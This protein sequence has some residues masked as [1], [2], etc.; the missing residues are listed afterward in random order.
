[1]MSFHLRLER[2]KHLLA[3]LVRATEY[4]VDLPTKAYDT[5]RFGVLNGH[6]LVS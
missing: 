6:A 1:M 5:E 2:K 4:G 3:A